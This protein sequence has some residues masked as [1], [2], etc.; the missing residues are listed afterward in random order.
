VPTVYNK[1]S[2]E[3]CFPYPL[4]HSDF[5]DA[6]DVSRDENLAKVEIAPL[7]TVFI[8]AA[9]LNIALLLILWRQRMSRMRVC[10]QLMWDITDRFLG[11]DLVCRLVKYLQVLGM[12]SSIYMIVV[13]T[14]DKYEAECNPMVKFQRTRTRL[15][16]PLL[17][18]HRFSFSHRS[19]LH[20]AMGLRTYITWT[21]MVIFCFTCYCTCRLPSAHLPSHPD[22]PVP[23]D[24][25]A[26]QRCVI[27]LSLLAGA[28]FTREPCLSSSPSPWGIRGSIAE[29]VRPQNRG[30]DKSFLVAVNFQPM[31]DP[32]VRH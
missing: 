5:V 7:S 27:V 28:T 1:T 8:S 25:T 18:C 13:I 22:Q 23:K 10:P 21:N 19:R 6:E 11:P 32:Q 2:L 26:S 15:N 12:F 24:S 20:P 30:G 31:C 14:F 3:T 17:G 29:R 4:N 16:I 9:L